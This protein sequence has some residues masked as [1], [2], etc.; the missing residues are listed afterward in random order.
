MPKRGRILFIGL[1][2]VEHLGK[3]PNQMTSAWVLR[4]FRWVVNMVPEALAPFQGAGGCF[5]ETGGITRGRGFNP[6]L[7]SLNPSGSRGAPGDSLKIA[8]NRGMRWKGMR[9][10]V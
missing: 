2:T 5:Q 10:K 3:N 6:R 1:F 4:C 9:S 7:L 8:K